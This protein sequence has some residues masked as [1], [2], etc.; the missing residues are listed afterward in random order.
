MGNFKFEIDGNKIKEQYNDVLHKV[1]E[2]SLIK[3]KQNIQET[4]KTYFDK[5]FFID[6]LT[7]FEKGLDWAIE[8]SFREGVDKAL[9]DLE[10]KEL[11]SEKTKEFLSENSLIQDLVEAK[12]RSSLGLPPKQ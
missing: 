12:I 9:R 1:I 8:Q 3:E 6:K 11:I 2:E 10:F 7:A 5:G 4:I